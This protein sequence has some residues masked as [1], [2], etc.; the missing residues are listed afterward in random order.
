M[1]RVLVFGLFHETHCFLRGSTG[2]RD[3][4]FME[5]PA[6]L[7]VRGESSPLGGFLEY[8][9]QQGWDVVPTLFATAVPGPMVEAEVFEHYWSRFEEIATSCLATG[10]DAIFA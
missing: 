4:E 7:N 5:G 1:F 3:F 10:V 2:L 6:I 9:D 8:A